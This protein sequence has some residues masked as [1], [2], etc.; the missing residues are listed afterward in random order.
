MADTSAPAAIIA[1][2]IATIA[3]EAAIAKYAPE[4]GYVAC[5]IT[6]LGRNFLFSGP[7]R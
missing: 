4:K 6:L 1:K 5:H 2:L 3:A 7:P